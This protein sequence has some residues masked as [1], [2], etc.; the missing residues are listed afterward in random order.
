MFSSI[1]GKRSRV[2]VQVPLLRLFSLMLILSLLVSPAG[3]S[4]AP[5]ANSAAA[6]AN[7]VVF[8][9]SDGMRPDLME[10]Y[11]AQGYMPTYAALMAAGVR[12]DNGMVQAFPPNTGVGWYTMM[13]GT[14]PG[15]HGSTNNTYHRSGE[16]S[17][18]NRT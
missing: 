11:A 9:S 12:G 7:R 15:E 4:A 13:T 6:I 5:A 3:V 2:S 10:Q 18:N 17:F 8:F 1:A 14:Y 16:A